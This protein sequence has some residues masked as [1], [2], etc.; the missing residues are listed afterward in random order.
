[1]NKTMNKSG[2]SDYPGLDTLARLR[3][4]INDYNYATGKRQLHRNGL[5]LAAA[6]AR[7]ANLEARV[8][9]N[10][11]G[12]AVAGEVV[13]HSAGAYLQVRESLNGH[14]VGIMWRRPK[15]RANSVRWDSDGANKWIFLSGDREQ[16]IRQL[17]HM[18]EQ[19]RRWETEALTG[20]AA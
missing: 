2:W 4:P 11:A 8:F 12:P 7:L 16:V 1:M 5:S 18:V 14:G 17:G 3:G 10:K 15:D 9:S 20:G 13:L 19:F 6:V